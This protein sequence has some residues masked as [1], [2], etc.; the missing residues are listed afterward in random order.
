MTLDVTHLI[1]LEAIKRLKYRY[2]RCI[3]QKLWDEIVECFTDDAT[4]AY[5]GGRHSTSGRAQV[6]E[7]LR[8]SMGGRKFTSHRVHQPEIDLTGPDTATGVW[9]MEDAVVD[10]AK[11][12]TVRGAGFYADEYVKVGGTWKIRATGYRRSYV[13]YHSAPELPGYEPAPTWW[14]AGESESDLQARLAR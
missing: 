10:V 12:R 11:K 4:V 9:A 13:E 8:R 5:D 3:D 2:M 6:V 7:F 14:F 1:E